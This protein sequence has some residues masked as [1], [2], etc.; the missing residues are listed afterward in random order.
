MIR[1]LAYLLLYVAVALGY[2]TSTYFAGVGR[3]EQTQRAV[4]QRNI[5]RAY[6]QPEPITGFACTPRVAR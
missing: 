1:R 3:G 5:C 6:S 4:D 2:G